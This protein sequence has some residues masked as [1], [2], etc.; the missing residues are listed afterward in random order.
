MSTAVSPTP[1]LVASFESARL[2]LCANVSELPD[3]QFEFA[4]VD[5]LSAWSCREPAL[6]HG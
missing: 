6:H 5:A 2:G 3:N 4:V 1:T